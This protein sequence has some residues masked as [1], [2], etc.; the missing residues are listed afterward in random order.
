[1]CLIH[2][3]C[4]TFACSLTMIFAYNFGFTCKYFSKLLTS[5][6][7]SWIQLLWH[8]AK[9]STEQNNIVYCWMSQKGIFSYTTMLEHCQ[10]KMFNSPCHTFPH[11]HSL[12]VLIFHWHSMFVFF[13]PCPETLNWSH[14]KCFCDFYFQLWKL[15]CD[16]KNSGGSTFKESD[17]FPCT[18]LTVW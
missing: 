15:H 9:K 12:T 7:S 8:E 5:F 3:G 1:M 2:T 17:C 18:L 13:I 11:I 14:W 6:A 10:W 16:Q 4:L